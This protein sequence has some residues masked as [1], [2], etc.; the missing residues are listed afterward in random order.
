MNQYNPIV[1]AAAGRTQTPGLIKEGRRTLGIIIIN[2]QMDQEQTKKAEAPDEGQEVEKEPSQPRGQDE[3]EKA[4][5]N[6]STKTWKS[7]VSF[8]HQYKDHQQEMKQA[9]VR[10]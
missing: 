2:L 7:I 9:V 10:T 4:L 5:Y 1:A 6:L 8:Y 3:F